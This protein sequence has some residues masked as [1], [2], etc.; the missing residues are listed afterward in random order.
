[1]SDSRNACDICGRRITGKPQFRFFEGAR[2]MVCE[3]C[4]RFA[5]KQPPPPSKLR[6]PE[7][8]RRPLS[9]TKRRAPK[10]KYKDLELRED[11]AE[12]IRKAREKRKWTQNDLA[13]QLLERLSLVRRIESGKLQPNIE[14]I[15]KLEKLLEIPLM[16]STSDIPEVKIESKLPSD[17]TLGDIVH[18][19]TKK[20]KE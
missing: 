15:E 7:K 6:E 3:I 2:L 16:L 20:K 10:Q 1:M 8:R 14:V 19:K 12:A 13:N 18:L 5:E 4:A 17:M 11:Y 9:K